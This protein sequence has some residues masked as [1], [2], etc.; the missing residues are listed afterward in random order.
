MQYAATL[1]PA[2]TLSRRGNAS[3]QP[4][5]RQLS[6]TVE[7]FALSAL[8]AAALL[9]SLAALAHEPAAPMPATWSAV[10]VGE[11]ATLWGI[12]EAHPVNGRSTLETLELIRAENGLDDYTIHA[13]QVLRVPGSE[14]AL[15]VAQ[16]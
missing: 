8:L 10:A 14:P 6:R 4:A 16:R 9:V 5:A 1:S 11:S 7:R 15:A 12:A 13:G 2:R 3:R